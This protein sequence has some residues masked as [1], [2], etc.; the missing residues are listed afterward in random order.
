MQKCRPVWIALI[1]FTLLCT[2][3]QAKKDSFQVVFLLGN[4]VYRSSQDMVFH[5]GEGHTHEIVL[6]GKKV[7]KRAKTLVKAI[8]SAD[9]ARLK[10]KKV[11]I[12]TSLKA[13]IQH[14]EKAITLGREQK[15]SVALDAAIKTAFHA[16]K[17][18]Q[19][20]LSIR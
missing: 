19:N 16:K 10:N 15:H 1:F 20:L 4:Q 12:I 2:A 6:Y 17:V 9:P 7:V 11:K 3:A 8:E 13:T 14:A 5:G 18:R